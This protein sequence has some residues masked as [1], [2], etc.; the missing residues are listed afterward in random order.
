MTNQQWECSSEWPAMLCR[1]IDELRQEQILCD[2]TVVCADG[3]LLAAH[4]CVLAAASPMLKL[5][6]KRT[7]PGC[8]VINLD[9]IPGT[10]CFVLLQFIYSGKLN[11]QYMSAMAGDIMKA[12]HMLQMLELMKLCETF[13]RNAA[14]KLAA[15]QQSA[16]AAVQQEH[17]KEHPPEGAAAASQ[18]AAPSLPPVEPQ[19]Q[20]E[21]KPVTVKPPD[22]VSAVI[23]RLMQ[24]DENQT[25]GHSFN[26]ESEQNIPVFPSASLVEE[27]NATTAVTQAAA[28]MASNPVSSAHQQ[29][30]PQ[31]TANTTA[32][33]GSSKDAAKMAQQNAT[34][35]VGM[36]I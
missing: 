27:E 30:F 25:N 19:V 8:F 9:H 2:T 12:S 16:Q 21:V 1:G 34:A 17:C 24:F 11:S 20:E 3:K 29:E 35:A 14:A 36:Y 15:Q 18:M 6:L 10:V 7:G 31:N 33:T 28:Y 32:D 23:D 13:Q 4:A 5:Q 22:N 26:G